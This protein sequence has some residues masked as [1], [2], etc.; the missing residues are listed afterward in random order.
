VPE[1]SDLTLE[2]RVEGDV[3]GLGEKQWDGTVRAVWGDGSARLRLEVDGDL[4]VRSTGAIPVASVVT[5]AGPEPRVVP[6]AAPPA[7]VPP[8]GGLERQSRPGADAD[9][10]VL[11]AVARGELSPEEADALLEAQGQR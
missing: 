7:P 1:D 4:S 9:L 8:F 11:E 3:S 5:P 10:A 2:G 6:P